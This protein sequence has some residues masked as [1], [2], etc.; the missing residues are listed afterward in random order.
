[1]FLVGVLSSLGVD[2]AR[3]WWLHTMVHC[4]QSESSLY[5]VSTRGAQSRWC[6]T[7]MGTFA[8]AAR[9]ASN[10][11][12]RTSRLCLQSPRFCAANAG[13]SL[14]TSAT[15]VPGYSSTDETNRKNWGC[16]SKAESVTRSISKVDV[17]LSVRGIL[18]RPLSLSVFPDKYPSFPV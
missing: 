13:C 12:V 1:M 7:F 11:M 4:C 15:E 9:V 3:V 2:G 17:E 10:R 6:P 5:R 16:L 14:R 18:C 8:R